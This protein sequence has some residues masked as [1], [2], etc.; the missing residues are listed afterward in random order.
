MQSTLPPEGQGMAELKDK[1]KFALDEARMLVLGCQVLLGF[2][3]RGFFEPRFEQLPAFAQYLKLGSLGMLLVALLLLILPCTVH[4]IVEQGE[5]TDEQH[6][7]TS[8]VMDYALLP[9]AVVI[10]LDIYVAINDIARQ[11]IAIAGA[12]SALLFTFFWWYGFEW[13][14]RAKEKGGSMTRNDSSGRT[15]LK[16]KIDHVLT[17]C[18]VV[19]PGV[20][21]LL[22][23]QFA[24]TLMESFEKLPE[25]SKQIHLASLGCM[26]A[27][28]VLLM[29]PA[30][31][32]R[33]VE[34]GE[35][36]ERFHR[37]ASCFMLSSL[38]PLALGLAG[39][40]FVVTRKLL[41]STQIATAIALTSI[42]IFYGAWF[43]ATTFV[44][45]SRRTRMLNEAAAAI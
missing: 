33:M 24:T 31:F 5:A 28:M 25:S 7:F 19:L 16:D 13:I 36:T 10:G 21:A 15:P 42:A 20:Q 8:T 38:V 14:V 32:H 37:V 43:G 23:F 30:A 18:R 6:R 29:T 27:S 11:P 12:V 3:F 4:R 1:V 44:R 2:Q 41:D 40:L 39:D 22:G 34:E 17:E 35:E 26:A 45:R 9:F